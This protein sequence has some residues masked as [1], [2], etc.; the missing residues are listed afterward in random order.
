[1]GTVRRAVAALAATALAGGLTGCSSDQ[2][3][4]PEQAAPTTSTTAPPVSG[5]TGDLEDPVGSV[6]ALSDVICKADA[7]GVW[8]A[9][10][11]LTNEEGVPRTYLVKFA[12]VRKK[13]SEV[14]SSKQ[15]EITLE[16]G[17][18]AKVRIADLH[19]G[20]RG[21]AVVCVPRVVSGSA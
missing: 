13:T 8:S 6:S 2:Q 20:K 15:K 12:V 11:T 7:A 3:E 4:Q 19:H 17:G 10:G 1:M 14:L 18:T 5:D 16:A 9:R 21:A